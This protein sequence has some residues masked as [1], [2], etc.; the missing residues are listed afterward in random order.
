M[1]SGLVFALVYGLWRR[2][3]RLS[4]ALP[5]LKAAAAAA[6][7]AAM[8]Y[9]LLAGFAVPAQRTVYM[10]AVVAA[11]LWLGVIES[12]TVVLCLALLIV[13]VVDPWAVLAPGFWLSFG[14]VAV[15]MYVSTGRIRRDH[16]LTSWARVQVAVSLALI[17]PLIAM[18][19]QVSIFSPLANAVAIPLVS[20][21]VAPLALLGAAL[22]FDLVFRAA[23]AVMSVCMAILEWLSLFPEAV[24]Q[25]PAPARWAILAAVPAVAWLLAPRG[26]PARWLGIIGLLPLVA[27][28]PA[29]IKAGD[30][31]IVVLDVGQGISTLV[32]TANH[33]LLYDTGPPFGPDADS[34]SRIIVPFLRAAG[35]A[36]LDGLIVSH[37]DDDHSGGAA[38]VLQAIPTAWMLT[39]LPDLDPLVARADRAWRCEAGQGWEWDGVR[40]EILH[41]A[42]GSYGVSGIRDNDRSCVLKVVAPGGS[43]LLPADIERRSEEALLRDAADRLPADVLLAP[44]QGSR[45]SSTAA[46][47][48]A[49]HPRIVVFPVGY[50]NRFGH[51]HPE[52]LERYRD[53]GARIYRSDRDGA[54]RIVI[55]VE[56]GISVSP[57]RAVYRRYWQTLLVGD[58]VPDPEELLA[59]RTE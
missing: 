31:E 52:V 25:Q 43:V 56:G 50:R 57:Y 38:S 15:I 16:W 26:L 46:F 12:A 23:H 33:A 18:F 3:P 39:S 55:H 42:P 34:G 2:V 44:H 45:T 54:V 1:V 59:R 37:D 20:L 36:K 53:F 7:T 13:V 49:V 5:A 6:L 21:L 48:R 19:Q 28:T 29:A 41:P 11:A 14:A 9:A 4:L 22:P 47:V 10:L 51:P 58:P 8:L 17:A 30:V 35:A 32:R 27:A 40:F 24:W